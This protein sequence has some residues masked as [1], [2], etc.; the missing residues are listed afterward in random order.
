MLP[1]TS[2]PL[3][4]VALAGLALAALVLGG[5]CTD[6]H[7]AR[8]KAKPT[9]GIT[10]VAPKSLYLRNA[11]DTD[12]SLYIGRFLDEGLPLDQLD[13]AAGMQK[14]CSRFVKYKTVGGGGVVYDEYYNAS[15]TASLSAQ[16]PEIA[17]VAVGGGVGRTV[18]VK[19]QLDTK[20]VSYIDD[21]GAF[22]AC[23]MRAPDQCS[24]R[25]IGE[26]LSGTGA[27]YFGSGRQIGADIGID[28]V[29]PGLDT[30]VF[31]KLEVKDAQTWER[32]IAFTQ[33]VYFAFKLYP[34]SFVG[35]LPDW[36]CDSTEVPRSSLGYYFV[37]V[38]NVQ[39]TAQLARD[40]AAQNARKQVVQFL[41]EQ[42]TT[43]AATVTS[44]SGSAAELGTQLAS[45]SFVTT[46]AEGLAR[47]VQV[48][49]ECP[50]Q[51]AMPTGYSHTSRVLG[52]VPEASVAEV[53]T[54]LVQQVGQ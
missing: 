9:D 16:I 48:V 14:S 4:P 17:T 20:M 7:A 31:P 24:S 32:S 30:K 29:I 27:V 38:S 51:V 41:G 2:P 33:P 25:Y 15:T 19:Y 3:A 49:K 13:E 5:A 40:E 39:D 1:R 21:P 35:K 11:F 43:G 50:A 47:Y 52:F 42:V 36:S 54:L 53:T 12:P 44:T 22:E 28:A 10:V 26:F 18:R 34:N 23:C 6:A 8:R 45:A 46:A 37:G